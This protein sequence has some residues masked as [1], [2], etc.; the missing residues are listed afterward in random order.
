MLG[1][2]GPFRQSKAREHRV[3]LAEFAALRAEILQALSMQWNVVALELTAT[4]VVF[5]LALSRRN[6]FLLLVL[7][8]VSY[9]LGNSYLSSFYSMQRLGSY[10]R[11]ELS[12]KLPGGL[13]WEEWHM[14]LPGRQYINLL[15]KT[16][17]TSAYAPLP[18]MFPTISVVALAWVSPY[19]IFDN[20]VSLLN[21][22][23]L[24][25][26]WILCLVATCLSLYSVRCEEKSRRALGTG[27]RNQAL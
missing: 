6:Y 5:S 26:I 9:A 21:R 22:L 2:K 19:I 7:P 23:F 10:I 20:H 17:L 8:I 12:P 11:E 13:L 4:G 14:K 15:Q 25:F 27:S 1:G 18:A 3:L 16:G 24:G